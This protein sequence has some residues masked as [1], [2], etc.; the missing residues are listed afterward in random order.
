MIQHVDAYSAGEGVKSRSHSPL[1]ASK[2][3]WLLYRG[4]SHCKVTYT[5]TNTIPLME[6]GAGMTKVTPSF[7]IE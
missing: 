4:I 3:D 2:S 6:E 7:T 5:H 1:A